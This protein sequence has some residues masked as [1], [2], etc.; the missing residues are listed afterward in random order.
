MNEYCFNKNSSV[1]SITLSDTISLRDYAIYGC[2]N[3]KRIAIRESFNPRAIRNCPSFTEYAIAGSDVTKYK[4]VDGVLYRGDMK[5]LVACPE[6]KKSVTINYGVTKIGEYAFCKSNAAGIT[7]P[8]SVTEIERYAFQ[9]SKTNYIK[10]PDS[11]TNIGEAAFLKV[12][13]E[14]VTIPSTVK[15]IG[16]AAFYSAKGLNNK[17]NLTSAVIGAEAFYDTALEEVTIGED[18]IVSTKAFQSCKKLKKATIGKGTLI[19]KGCFEDCNAMTDIITEGKLFSYAFSGLDG[20]RNV[21]LL[22]GTELAGEGLFFDC[23]QV[24]ELTL[25]EGMESIDH[26]EVFSG[27]MI[28]TLRIPSTLK[29]MKDGALAGVTRLSEITVAEGNEAYKMVDGVLYSINGREIIKYLPTKSDETFTIPISVLYISIGA[30]EHSK[31]R[32]IRLE[33]TINYVGAGAFKHSTLLQN[34]YV[35]I[36]N[37]P[38]NC[39]ENCYGLQKVKFGDAVNKLETKAF[40]N[41]TDLSSVD[42]PGNVKIIE[43]ECFRYSSDKMKHVTIPEGVS[44]LGELAFGNINLLSIELP[45]SATLPEGDLTC[46]AKDMIMIVPKSS[47][48]AAYAAARNIR[49]VYKEDLDSLP[50]TLLYCG[51]ETFEI[52]KCKAAGNVEV[53]D[54][55]QSYKVTTIRDGAFK[56]NKDITSVVVSAGISSIGEEAFMGCKGLESIRL[57]EGLITIGDSAF[58]DCSKLKEIVIPETVQSAGT[59]LLF[60]GCTSLEK[61]ELP[62]RIQSIGE[63]MFYRCEKLSDFQ[64]LSSVQS[65]GNEAFCGCKALKSIS[66]P[67]SVKTIGDHAIGFLPNGSSYNKV[68]GFSM[69][70]VEGSAAY[71]YAIING[72]WNNINGFDFKEL[73]DG[74]LELS[75]YCGTD[76]KITIPSQRGERPV[77]SLGKMAFLA[78]ENLLE[79]V[80]PGGVTKIGDNAFRGCRKIQSISIPETVTQIGPGAFEDVDS[81]AKITVAA[82][83]PFYLCEDDILYN[84]QK[85]ELIRYIP[86]RK[87][88][89]FAVPDSVQSIAPG[90][91]NGSKNILGITFPAAVTNVG[92][93]AF[94]G[95]ENLKLVEI[96]KTVS[97]IGIRAFGYIEGESG[98]EKNPGFVIRAEKD[99]AAWKYATDNGF[100]LEEIVSQSGGD[101]PVDPVDPNPQKGD[102]SL[103]SFQ[104]LPDAGQSGYTY[105]L[106]IVDTDGITHT[107]VLEP[108]PMIL[109]GSTVYQAK[110]YL[111]FVPRSASCQWFEGSVCKGSV[112]LTS[113]QLDAAKGGGVITSDGSVY[114]GQPRKQNQPGSGKTANPVKIKAAKKTVKRGALAKKA[115]RVKPFT[116]KDAKGTLSFKIV[117]KG[118]NAKIY[119]KLKI[120]KK[121]VIT[122]K[123]CKLKKGNYKVKVK[124]TVSGDDTYEEKVLTKTVTLK[125]K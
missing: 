72:L 119:K 80:I 104:F 33:N 16:K 50:Y 85:T 71:E 28:E 21:T 61:A 116:I 90:A 70:C 94:Y 105:K 23:P 88:M 1:E 74:S 91:F 14:S 68:E 58:E 107:Y 66:V 2:E 106:I 52:T 57:S 37:V 46:F 60:S 18:S 96:P 73:A 125:V 49:F 78:N 9:Y 41:C 86:K 10:L 51:K 79:V 112:A 22:P 120:S 31:L 98:I 45:S 38:Q 34:A 87:A 92:A 54:T 77:T 115:Q 48:A 6:G 20:L 13:S 8:S 89:D 69:I 110:V 109:D 24:T 53:S 27:S 82:S 118:T 47:K 103:L 123:K 108:T 97:T 64:I 44:E 26:K 62:L 17:L 122:V 7:I 55:F 36:Q 11:I 39:F 3:L 114:N 56:N 101:N 67:N 100:T 4:A 83:N 29:Q 12:N 124:I 117:K 81:L 65:I 102:G 35:N 75:R 19:N 121:G 30:F 5:T 111:D 59:N 25:P 63:R 93:E 15:K 84:K 113:A 40:Y 76:T 99:T 32:E 43:S 95:C 42:I